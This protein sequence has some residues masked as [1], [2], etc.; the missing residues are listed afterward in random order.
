MNKKNTKKLMKDFPKLYPEYN[1]LFASRVKMPFV[2]DC[3]DGWFDLIYK[4]SQDIQRVIDNTPDSTLFKDFFVMQVKQKWGLLRY[5]VSYG[6][7]E[8][9]DLIHKA[10][11]E[12]G[13]I[14]EICGKPGTLTVKHGFLQTL[15]PY[16]RKKKGAKEV[17]PEEE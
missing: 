11:G 3:Q 9:F 2:F 6:T 10:E 15:C 12:S 13:H 4:L 16:H 17:E 14:C 5:Y 7:D 1:P 8:I